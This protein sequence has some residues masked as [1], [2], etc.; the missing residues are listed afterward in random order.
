MK[1]YLYL[2]LIITVPWSPTYYIREAISYPISLSPLA[3]IVATLEI[4][5]LDL[6]CTD[7]FFKSS[8][9]AATPKLIPKYLFFIN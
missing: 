2:C 8:T 1:K 5:S 7:L 9:I 3:E 6:T 4:Y